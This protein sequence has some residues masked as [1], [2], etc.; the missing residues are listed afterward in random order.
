MV[1]GGCATSKDER[2]PHG[3]HTM[4]DVWNQETGGSAGGG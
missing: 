2:L 3:E 1:L 4:L